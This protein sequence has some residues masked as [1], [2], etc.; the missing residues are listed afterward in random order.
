[1]LRFFVA[2]P[3]SVGETYLQHLRNAMG[4]AGCLG[5]AALACA[6]HAVLPFLFVHTASD[7]VHR[8]H[9]RMVTGR[10]NV[11]AGFRESRDAATAAS[12]RP[13]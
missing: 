1:M 9:A 8:L 6:L 12:P 3:A 5:W 4:F 2:H 7:A 11:H 10:R 13:Q